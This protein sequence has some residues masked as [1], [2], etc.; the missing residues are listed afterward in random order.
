MQASKRLLALLIVLVFALGVFSGCS[1]TNNSGLDNTTAN[2]DSVLNDATD[3]T[4]DTDDVQDETDPDTQDETQPE[5]L[6]G[7]VYS[8]YTD[9]LYLDLYE[10]ESEI[11]DYTT[12]DL[13]SLVYSGAY[14]EV[15][16]EDVTYYYILSD[17]IMSESSLEEIEMGDF[18]AVSY[19]EDGSKSIII[20]AKAEQSTVVAEVTAIEDASLTVTVYEALSE[21]TVISDYANVDMTGYEAT[22]TTE[23]YELDGT[24]AFYIAADGALT[25]ATADDIT[26]GD[27]LIFYTDE[28]GLPAIVIY[29]AE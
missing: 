12:L 5:D 22:E 26:V 9:A 27:M 28:Y 16:T 13:D 29:P 24:E 3:A 2:T 25:D 23:I 20:L 4:D 15:L 19:A 10:A 14:E 17:G 1:N 8:V 7:E 11:E 21:G 6:I 18:V